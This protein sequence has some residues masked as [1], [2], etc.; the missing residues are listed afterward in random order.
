MSWR[1]SPWVYPVWDSLQLL[2]LI[3]YF[4][5]HVGEIF[6]YSLFKN[7]LIRF[8]FLLFF[9]VVLCISCSVVS[10]A[11]TPR[12]VTHLVSLSMGFSRQNYWMGLS[13]PSPEDLPN[14]GIKTWSP[15][16][17]ADCFPFELQAS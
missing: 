2:D 9:C 5:F 3:D 6:N 14:Q 4:L 10:D 16:L 11:V 17:Q 8:L 1:V 12:T 13:F 15:A 7:F